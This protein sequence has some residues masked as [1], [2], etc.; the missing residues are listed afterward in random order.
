[1]KT[2]IKN[3]RNYRSKIGR[4]D[5]NN[6][7]P[8]DQTQSSRSEQASACGARGTSDGA[9]D[10]NEGFS[11]SD[12]DEGNKENGHPEG[13]GSGTGSAGKKRKATGS[14]GSGGKGKQRKL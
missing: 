10:E 4:R 11:D 14:G 9:S 5:T 1:M 7:E 3:K 8:P 12:I 13:D 2:I 6:Q